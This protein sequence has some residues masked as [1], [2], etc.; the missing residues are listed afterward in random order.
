[1]PLITARPETKLILLLLASLATSCSVLSPPRAPSKIPRDFKVTASSYA[2]LTGLRQTVQ[3]N[4]TG[5]AQ[6]ET[7]EGGQV[8]ARPLPKVKA[9]LLRRIIAAAEKVDF[10]TLRASYSSTVT[11]GQ[12]HTLE[13]TLDGQT[14]KVEVE[15]LRQV[16]RESSDVRRFA[17]VWLTVVEATPGDQPAANGDGQSAPSY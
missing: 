7:E 4:A 13:I 1:M 9:S 2:I 17:K 14:H 12:F 15:A 11:D 6:L 3:I 8:A 10:F 5:E 16:I